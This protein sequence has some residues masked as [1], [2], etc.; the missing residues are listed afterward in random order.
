MT[1]VETEPREGGRYRVEALDTHGRPYSISGT[2]VELAENERVV[3]SWNY[4]GPVEALRAKSTLVSA[5]L[6]QLSPNLT[7]LTVTHENNPTREAAG[8]HKVG[9]SSCLTKLEAECAAARKERPADERPRDFF[10]DGHRKFQD[11]F[12]TRQLADRLE[13]ITIHDRL[14]ASDAAFISRQNMFFIATTDPYGQPNCSYKGGSRGFVTVIDDETVAFPDFDGNG[15]HLTSGNISEV[16][17]VGL[18]FVDFERQ[19]RLCVLGRAKVSATDSLLKRYPGAQMMVRVHVESV[20]SNCPRYVHKMQ[21]IE[22]SVF[23][24]S[25]DQPRQIPKWK[26]LHS[27]AD[28]LPEADAD[29]AG[30]DMDAESAM[31][32][33]E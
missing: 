24:P 16:S 1:S 23:V 33:D 4:D 18:L 21:L 7:E 30:T 19:A 26:R 25:P 6:R 5:E 29:A 3:M 13:N 2:Y 14:K 8:L 11:H 32:Q 31:N 28:A 17:R 9:W 10:T 22:E 20:F 12:G 27:V 15:M